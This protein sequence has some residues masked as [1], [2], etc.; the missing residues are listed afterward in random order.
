M[1]G[2]GSMLKD[3]LE[4]NLI[5]Q[6]DFANR[7]GI[8][9]KH[10]NEIL[11]GKT[12]ISED[13]MIAISLIT[14]IDINLIA[15][16]EAKKKLY[17]YLNKR[18]KNENEIKK[19]IN[20]YHINEMYKRNWLILKDK[21]SYL[22][23][24]YDLLNFLNV[25]DFD[26]FEKYSNNKILYKKKEDAD[27]KKVF[28]WITRCDCL[29]KNKQIDK[30]DSSNLSKL[31]LELKNERVK[32]FNSSNLI[33]LFNKYGIYLVVEDALNGSKVRGCTKVL[34]NHPAIYMTTYLK[35][36]ASFYF[37]LYHEL[38]HVK[39]DYNKA[40][41]KVIIDGDDDI[42][43]RADAFAL[44]QMIEK[45]IYKDILD[46]YDNK[47]KICKD[48]KIPLCFLY[49]RLAKEGKINYSDELCIKNRE[50]ITY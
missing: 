34:G 14:D 31:L 38:G 47:E 50:S 3:Y 49:S 8:T 22:Q 9:K 12:D 17:N 35:E 45:E 1:Y 40:K 46:N 33:K 7:L 18:F 29:V 20:S 25:K 13:L 44:N 15:F 30:Y 41:N 2:F 23:N 37:A 36:K 4:Y 19:Y 26:T 6:S 21:D 10:M 5:S 42:E 39:S 24:A 43:K 48:K 28:L 27:L 11:N 16:V 32:K